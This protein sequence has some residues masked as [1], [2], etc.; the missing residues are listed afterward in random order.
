V[1][2]ADQVVQITDRP[3]RRGGFFPLPGGG[4]VLTWRALTESDAPSLEAWDLTMGDI[5]LF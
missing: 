4:P 5:E 3:Y 2:G 1:S